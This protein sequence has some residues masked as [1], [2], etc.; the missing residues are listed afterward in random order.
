MNRSCI[1]RCICLLC[2]G[3]LAL[4]LAACKTTPPASPQASG[5]P[6][7]TPPPLAIPMA[8]PVADRPAIRVKAGAAADWKDAKG[9]VWK[10]DTGFE[11]GLTIDR[12]D[13]QVT[14]TD[15]PEIYRS[16]HYSMTSWSAKAPNGKYIL[17]LHFSEDYDGIADENGRI[18]TYAVKDGDAATGRVVKEVKGFGP[19]K[20]AKARLKA[21]VDLVPIDVT[22]GQITV[23]FTPGVENPQINAIEVVPQ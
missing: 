14:G 8:T 10:A 15:N 12:P 6:T 23:V 17:K 18:F 4:P 20:A 1:S 19:W 7:P 16:E 3:L 13:L 11:G 22:M 5:A 2:A 9:V 21:Y